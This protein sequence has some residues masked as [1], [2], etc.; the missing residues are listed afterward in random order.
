MSN[1]F[2][3][4][5][6]KPH[7]AL[8][9]AGRKW[10]TLRSLQYDVFSFEKRKVWVTDSPAPELLASEGYP[11]D[12]DGWLKFMTRPFRAH[13]LPKWMWLYDLRKPKEAGKREH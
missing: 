2:G 8:I 9:E 4:P 5:M 3:V 12:R 7:I 10:T 6:S 13:K 11:D 1:W